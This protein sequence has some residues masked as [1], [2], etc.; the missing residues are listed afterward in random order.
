[1]YFVNI[2]GTPYRRKR[3]GVHVKSITGETS[4]LTFVRLD[5]GE[6]TDHSHPS[7]QLGYVISGALAVT[8]AGDRRVLRP[9]D[10]Y[11]IPGGVRHG[12][13]VVSDGPAEYV[14]VFCPP[15]PENR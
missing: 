4:Q 15:K 10:G 11:V 9:G 3:A 2:A 1:M 8:V 13:A 14:E 6:A 7:E 5:P 12:F